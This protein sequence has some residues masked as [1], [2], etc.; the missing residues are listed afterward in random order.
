M[1]RR[2]V[3][4]NPCLVATLLVLGV[5]QSTQRLIAPRVCLVGG[6]GMDCSGA[7]CIRSSRISD[8]LLFADHEENRRRTGPGAASRRFALD[9]T[10][11]RSSANRHRP[12]QLPFDL[13][14]P[15]ASRCPGVLSLHRLRVCA[16]T[17]RDEL[18]TPALRPLSPDLLVPTIVMMALAVVGLRAFSLAD[19]VECQLGLA[20]HSA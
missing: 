12:L 4:L 5:L 18:S 3:S 7:R 20:P 19:F 9:A 11:W 2:A 15:P 17:A 16:D 6:S 8:S 1:G 10:I 13:A 14:Q